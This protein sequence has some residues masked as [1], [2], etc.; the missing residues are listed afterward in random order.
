MSPLTALQQI[1]RVGEQS[2]NQGN[3][4]ALIIGLGS[5]AALCF[6]VIPLVCLL[7]RYFIRR[8][9][10]G[11]HN[12]TPVSRGRDAVVFSAFEPQPPAMVRMHRLTQAPGLTLVE[13]NEA[14]PITPYKNIVG[15]DDDDGEDNVCAVCLEEMDSDSKT[16]TMPCGHTFD[17]R[18]IE[19]WATKAN[20][21]PVCNA[22]VVETDSLY[23]KRVAV[24]EGR[25]N[26]NG[27]TRQRRRRLRGHNG[28]ALLRDG[29]TLEQVRENSNIVVEHG[30]MDSLYP[31]GNVLV[32]ASSDDLVARR[33]A[34]I[35][36]P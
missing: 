3:S 17:A 2:P 5:A 7:R 14:A 31:T 21:C 36:I 28:R 11:L 20:R 19:E 10:R 27:G 15:E 22:H 35:D 26:N 25:S 9:N 12:D 34:A 13:L 1:S 18:C 4:K 29:M 32:R 24:L 33:S 6:I 30:P 8:R 23:R 16:R